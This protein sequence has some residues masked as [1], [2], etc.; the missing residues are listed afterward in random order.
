[1]TTAARQK[2]GFRH[3]ALFYA[4]ADEFLAVTVAFV[5]EG[6]AAEDSI[7]VAL[8]KPTRKLLQGALGS[9]AE[10][11]KFVAM[12][13]L[14][15]NPG[16]IISA[17]HDFLDA[18]HRPGDGVRGIG[19]PAWAGRTDEELDECGR[20]ELM[21][22]LA[23]DDGPAWPLMCPYDTSALDDAVLSAAEHNHPVLS[24]KRGRSAPYVRHPDPEALLAGSLM[25][26]D[27]VLVELAF[28]RAELS[29]LRRLVSEHARLAGLDSQRAEDLVLVA[30]E[31]ATNSVRFGGGGGDLRIWRENGALICDVHDAGQIDEPLVG[32]RRPAR[33]QVGGRGVWIAHQLCDLVQIRSGEDGTHVRLQMAID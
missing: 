30:C 11:V 19:E 29:E 15:R 26:P 28:G 6:I 25:R 21:L 22:N 3:E 10:R 5:E 31:V 13:Q 17:W 20:H 12:E 7:L 23:F 1:L 33:D 9:E 32:R 16:R 18:N 24:G 27:G 14:G 4:D 8:P 2:D